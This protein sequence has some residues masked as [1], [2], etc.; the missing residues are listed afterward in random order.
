[1]EDLATLEISRAQVW[2]WLR[3]GVELE[4]GSKVTREHVRAVF[5]AELA[6]I[7]AE[8]GPDSDTGGQLP[9]R[10]RRGGRIFTESAFRPFLT[11]ASAPADA[12]KQ[13]L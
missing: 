5:A 1:M 10:R 9:P 12:T 7:L 3:H 4:D 13:T 11:T 8:L 2:Q 6:R